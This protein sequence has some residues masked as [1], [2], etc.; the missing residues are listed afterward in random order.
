MAANRYAGQ[1]NGC[2]DTVPANAGVCY[3]VGRTWIVRCADYCAPSSSSPASRSRCI[4]SPCCG[5]CD[6]E[7]AINPL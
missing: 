2:G 7:Y 3:R 1:C 6:I 4:D 5:C